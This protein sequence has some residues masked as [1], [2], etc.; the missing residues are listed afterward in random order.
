MLEFILETQFMQRGIIA[1]ML[2][3]LICPLIGAFIVVRRLSLISEALSHVTLAGVGFGLF[4]MT[5]FT[6]FETLNPLYAGTLFAVIGALF[7]DRLRHVYKQYQELS[8]PIVL[9][10]GLGI[11]I[12]F[13]SIAQSFNASLLN[14]FFGSIVSVT[15]MDL[16]FIIICSII[17]VVTL[18]LFYKELLAL[19]FDEE[20]AKISGIPRA[21][22]N[23]I[24]AILIAI[25][26]SI[27]MR[28]VGILLVSSLI[29]IPVAASLRLAK[30][31]KQVLLY[32]VLIA[33]SS[34]IS[35]LI[36]AYYLQVATGGMVVIM[37]I[38]HLLLVLII[39]KVAVRW[40]TLLR[41]KPNKNV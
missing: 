24:F 37:T 25:T 20:F 26:I 17:I 4:L 32:A 31:F 14:F 18:V 8:I 3:A 30:S 40:Q 15:A 13:M 36:L 22:I 28:V 12:V 21:L 29:T 34:M 23:L 11:G 9:S 6:L 35:G 5:S 2:V 10:A 41:M 38:V 33:Q 39:Q 7:I 16:R 27:A 19:S 1:G